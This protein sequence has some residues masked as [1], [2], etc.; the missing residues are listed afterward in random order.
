MMVSEVRAVT[1]SVR[2]LERSLEFYENAFGY[3]VLAQGTLPVDE[4]RKSWRMPSDLRGEYAVVGPGTAETG[5]LRLV[6]F[7]SAG[8]SIWGDYSRIQDYGHY[9]INFRALDVHRTWEKLCAAGARPKSPPK[10]WTVNEQISAWDS[11]CFDPDGVLLDVFQVEGQVLETLGEQ[12][13]EVSEVQTMAIHVSDMAQSVDF[14]S[15]LGFSV[16]YDK[17]VDGMENFFGLPRGTKLHNVNLMMPG[18]SPNGRVELAQYIGFPGRSI[19]DRAMPP[20]LGV[21]TMSFESGDIGEDLQRAVMLGG[22]Q[23]AD[24]VEVELTP[25]GKVRAV[26]CLGPDGEAVELYQPV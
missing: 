18:S 24:P 13:A 12:E 21:L 25:W 9:A 3:R 14:Y 7:S 19:G 2:D 5:L 11:M 17:V 26:V 23:I 10:Y 22:S 8:V 20:N 1:V 4:L 6:S 15:G 16:L